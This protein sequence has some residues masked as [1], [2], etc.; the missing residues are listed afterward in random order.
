[1]DCI[2]F[3]SKHEFNQYKILLLKALNTG[4]PP[5]LTALL[6]RKSFCRV[7]RTSQK[8]NILNVPAHGKGCHSM[9]AFSVVG[10]TMWNEL[11]TNELRECT[12]VDVFKNRLH[13]SSPS[14]LLTV[15]TFFSRIIS[16]V[17]ILLLST[18]IF[19]CNCHVAMLTPRTALHLGRPSRVQRYISSMHRAM[20]GDSLMTRYDD[21][22]C[23]SVNTH[24]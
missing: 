6:T 18:C 22:N 17:L 7:T 15:I 1:M 20:E 12:S 9:K 5:Y 8:V 10:P 23:I 21:C 3:P 2:G 24:D 11:L 19:H 14:S 4:T 13:S 16:E